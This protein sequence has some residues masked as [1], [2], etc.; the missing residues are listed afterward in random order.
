M[1]F[2]DC[3]IVLNC[4]PLRENDCIVTVFTKDNGKFEVNFKSVRLPKAKLRALALPVSNGDYRFYLKKGS[5]FPVCTGGHTLNVFSRIRIDLQCLQ[6]ALHYCEIINRI[7]PA[8]QKS[9]DK[10]DLLN[11]ALSDLNDNSCSY[12]HRRSFTLR[13]LNYAGFGFKETATGLSSE[14]WDVLHEGLWQQVRNLP[15]DSYAAGY[16]DK[17][18][19]KFFND[20][21]IELYTKQFVV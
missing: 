4:R 16:V 8:W 11:D 5:N 12:W 1:Y 10:Y 14:L 21:H 6:Q 7:T 13:A 17:L 15:E 20:M 19:D 2:T 9:E 3:G 18:L